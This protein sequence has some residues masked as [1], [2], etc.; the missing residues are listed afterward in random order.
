[1]EFLSPAAIATA[2]ALTVPPLVA[3]Y[4][5]KLKREAKPISST[6]LWKKAVQDLRV[7]APFQRLR[8]SLLLFLQLLVLALAALAL[9]QPMLHTVE[10]H[11]DTLILLVDQ[12]ASMGV[13]ESD[14]RTRLEI[15]KEQAKRSLD[16]MGENARAMVIAFCDRATVVSSFDTDKEALIRKIDSIEQTQSTS[17]LGEAMS[18]AEAYTQDMIIARTG[19]A[20]LELRSNAPPATVTLFTDGRIQDADKV[21]L[22]KFDV[23]RIRVVTVG[24]RGDNVGIVAMNAR[25]HY[26]RPQFLEVTATVRNFGMRK[27]NVDAT[28]Y[29]DE[30]LVD[31]KSIELEPGWTNE[32]ADANAD[33]G[34]DVV[35]NPLPGSVAVVAF[36][37]IEFEGEGVV[38]VVLQVDDAL[39]ADDRAWTIV[40]SP[41]PTRVLIVSDPNPFFDPFGLALAE[42]PITFDR[43]TPAEY[44]AADND[45]IADG[46]RSR[47]DVVIFD[48]H[49]TSRLPQGNYLFFGG[50]PEIDGVSVDGTVDDEVIFNWDETHPVLRHVSVESIFVLEW[51]RLSLP[52]EAVSLVDGATTPVMAYLAR[53]A[54]QY[55]IVAFSL[56]NEDH[57][58]YSLNT[59]WV[60]DPD[61]VVFMHNAVNY[62]AAAIATTGKKSVAPG[63]P[64]TLP[65]PADV[66]QV[67]VHRPDDSVDADLAVANQKL[68]YGRTHL[69]GPYHVEPGVPGNDAFTVNLF[70]ALESFVRPSNKV[71]LGVDAVTTQAGSV[72]VNQ[73]AWPYFVLALLALLLIE[74]IVYNRRVFV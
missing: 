7:N 33:S 72:D 13:I 61:F 70:N 24:S 35:N 56:L 58:R 50:I 47:Y 41:E 62:L 16:N 32:G 15:A 45:A 38:E 28:V 49:S 52:P 5:L 17:N 40:S 23:K 3:L 57:G 34:A 12:S 4:F 26:E 66:E 6:L 65:L 25:R 31:V 19:E 11:E 73:P 42:S 14:G 53:D 37:A 71:T 43:M 22:Q 74:W 20:D 27:V 64:V 8:S 54:S 1:M 29:V 39:K 48:R 36:D 9:G 30:R 51:N 21:A 46:N 60:A 59:P 63:E 18:L 55:L 2:A 68:H 44:E 69:V 67:T 10:T